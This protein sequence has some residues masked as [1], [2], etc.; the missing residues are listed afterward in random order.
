MIAMKKLAAF[1]VTIAMLLSLIPVCYAAEDPTTTLTT[2][3]ESFTE[4]VTIKT[5]DAEATLQEVFTENPALFYYFEAYSATSSKNGKKSTYTFTYH[6]TDT[7]LENIF[8][9]DSEETLSY[10]VQ[11]ALAEVTETVAIV[12]TDSTLDQ[13][14][15]IS[16]VD[17]CRSDYYLAY[18]GYEGLNST[19]YTS[20]ESA[21]S[22]WTAYT[23]S[24]QYM[25]DAETIQEWRQD[26]ENAVLAL[27]TTLFAQDMPDW[28]K[29]LLIHDYIVENC[30]YDEDAEDSGTYTTANLAYGCLVEGTA[31]C[32]GYAET[33]NLLFKA[34]GLN[35]YYVE[36]AGESAD[37]AWNCVEIDGDYYWVDVTWDDPVPAEGEEEGLYHTY[38]NLTDSELN[39]DHS[40]VSS[41]YPSC[42][43]TT[44]AYSAVKEALADI[45]DSDGNITE[46]YENYSTDNVTLLSTLISDLQYYLGIDADA[47]TDT[48]DET[49]S[50]DT[51]AEE[52]AVTETAAE[53]ESTGHPV[54]NVVIAVLIILVVLIIAY[55]IYRRI[56]YLRMLERRRR[57]RAEARRRAAARGRTASTGSSGRSRSSSS[58][59]SS[60][61]SRSSAGRSSGQGRSS[62]G[63]SGSSSSGRS[64]SSSSR[65]GSSNRSSSRPRRENPFR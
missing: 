9:V 37:H 13:D 50:T 59:R 51:A 45:T 10:V 48:T 40:W 54:R 47:L 58:N 6:N 38:F 16:A 14:N 42:T 43:A 36:G 55:L 29:V 2:A 1:C 34:A 4:E 3:I 26:T 39:T 52:T 33:A 49:E 23:L 46:V 21:F 28:Y 24:F 30:T 62:S 31:V 44:W 18:M 17:T 11:Y 61:Q 32:E 27:C 64:R 57:R 41:Q 53:E 7:A 65:S 56:M 22:T 25:E 60:G 20:T 8:V 19:T 63:R 5:S 35:S 12:V 15:I